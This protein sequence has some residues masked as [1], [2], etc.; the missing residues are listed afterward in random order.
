MLL[1][2]NNKY[3]KIILFSIEKITS[4]LMAGSFLKVNKIHPKLPVLL[5]VLIL[6]VE[7]STYVLPV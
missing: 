6:H 2:K 7:M 5:T 1:L 3:F 4:V